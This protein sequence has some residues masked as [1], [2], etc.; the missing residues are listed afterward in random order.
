MDCLL[1][2]VSSPAFQTLA[3]FFPSWTASFSSSSTLVNSQLVYLYQLGF[4]ITFY[5]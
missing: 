2:L 5:Y 4:V 3:I 1:I